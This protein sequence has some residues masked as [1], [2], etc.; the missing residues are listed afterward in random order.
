LT[1]LEE[2]VE[3]KSAIPSDPNLQQRALFEQYTRVLRTLADQRPLLLALDDLQWADP[4]TIGLL[5]N[6]GRRLERARIVLVGAY[7][8]AEVAAGGP[9]TGL[10]SQKRH[11]LEPVVNEL[12][13]YYGDIEIDLSQAENRQFIDAWLDTEPNRLDK[14][15]RKTL[16]RQTGGHPL[17]TVELLRSMQEQGELIQDDAG[18]WVEG[19]ALD[20]EML[21]TRVEAAIAER[22]GRLPE[23][24][25]EALNVASAEGETFTAEV[26]AQV[27]GSGE[28]D[29]V[30]W[31]SQ[32]LEREH[33][34]VSA[35]GVQQVDGKRLS[36]YQFRHILFQRY[37][38]HTLNPAERAYLHEAVGSALEELYGERAGEIAVHLARHFQEAGIAD[39][40][41]DYLH[42]AGDRAARLSAHQEAIAHFSQAL[43]L[44]EGLPE[45]PERIRRELDLQLA[46]GVALVVIKGQAAPEVE[47]T[48]TRA[49]ELSEH[50]C[51]GTT[52]QRFQ[53][54]LGLGRANLYQGRLRTAQAFRERFLALAQSVGDARHLSRAHFAQAEILLQLGEFAQIPKHC[55][56]GMVHY[57]PQQ[58]SLH[59]ALYGNDTGIGGL[60]E[61]MAMWYL[62]Y[63]DRALKLSQEMVT[64]AQE[65]SHP[66]SLSFTLYWTAF[67]HQLRREVELAKEWVEAGLRISAEKGFALYT[68]FG[69]VL[70]GWALAKQGEVNEGI[71]HMQQGLDAW[72]ET[73]A[74]VFLPDLL[75][76][77]AEAYGKAGQA[78][79]GLSLVAE[80]LAL[81]EKN[82]ERCWEA[83]LHRLKGELLLI[84]QPKAEVEAEVDTH[85][86][87]AERCFERALAVARGQGAKSWELRAAMSLCRLQRRHGS[88]TKREAAQSTLG[89]V[90]GWFSE[91]FD[92]ADLREAKALLEELS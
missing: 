61:A 81:V 87:N 29:T 3:R 30:R 23:H 80:A 64:L 43:R 7:R 37:L 1:G 8:P 36:R 62:G 79:K 68:A 50:E 33:R 70:R 65:L 58:H 75:A 91:G 53:V 88:Q 89:E 86:Q 84:H 39:K 9:S 2:L 12:R 46:A 45:T 51:V 48:Y 35:R 42:Q 78:E 73:G 40:A 82:G 26:V 31:L 52:S 67:I 14:A 90:Y 92:T 63:P 71:T 10:E 6:L 25:R 49:L 4:G 56:Q 27:H 47:A 19:R 16:Y 72:R 13:H 66:Y 11:P 85:H 76:L 32:K 38:Y 60:F 21:P 34:L 83:E 22:I 57:D 44:L 69:T 55:Q 18:C 59:V 24:L 5:F 74:A 77:L 28:R 54:L 15:F 20:W 17:F 41:V